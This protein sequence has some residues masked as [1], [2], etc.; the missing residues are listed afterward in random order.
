MW[1]VQNCRDLAQAAN[2][3]ESTAARWRGVD[4]YLTAAAENFGVPPELVAA[5]AFVESRFRPG[6]VSPAGA[7]GLMQT[8]PGTGAW[9]AEQLGVTYDPFDP[10]QSAM[11]GAYYLRR[12]INRFDG[13]STKVIAAYNAGAGAVQKHGGV[14]PFAETQ[15][16][17]PA[18]TRAYNAILASRTRC[19]TQGG[20]TVPQWRESS[21]YG[22]GSSGSGPSPSKPS[23][24]PSK[25]PSVS[26]GAGFGVLALVVLV[27]LAVRGSRG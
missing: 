14:P 25:P 26:S 17:V 6:A 8:M 24:A 13:D 15:A 2:L 12:L 23:P 4:P 5:V 9:L 1:F 22:W 21:S 20:G 16:Y 11:L 3:P 19:E 27:A 7:Q 18:V 10:E